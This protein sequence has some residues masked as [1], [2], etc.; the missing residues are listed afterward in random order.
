M[1]VCVCLNVSSKLGNPGSKYVE[2][3]KV[4]NMFLGH[5]YV[6]LLYDGLFVEHLESTRLSTGP[7]F[8]SQQPQAS[9]VLAPGQNL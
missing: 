8:C 6:A 5:R 2:P 3:S 7:E 1:C 9:R 4:G